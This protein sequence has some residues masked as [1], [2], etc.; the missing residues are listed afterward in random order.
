MRN[1][2][3]RP[4]SPGGFVLRAVG[5]DYRQNRPWDRLALGGIQGTEAT[6]SIIWRASEMAP[7]SEGRPGNPTITE[8]RAQRPWGSSFAWKTKP[9]HFYFL[10]VLY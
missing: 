4:V 6:L 2:F 10:S 3:L 8:R 7:R 9:R 5:G 1:C